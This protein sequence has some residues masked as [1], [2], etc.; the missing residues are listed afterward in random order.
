VSGPREDEVF[1]KRRCL[2][3][4]ESQIFS[5]GSVRGCENCAGKGGGSGDGI[6]AEAL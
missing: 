2:R 6:G 5:P 1:C 4:C 3:E